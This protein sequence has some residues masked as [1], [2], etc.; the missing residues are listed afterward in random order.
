[1]F[2]PEQQKTLD[3]L[4]SAI[5]EAVPEIVGRNATD[6]MPWTWDDIGLEDVLRALNTERIAPDFRLATH[7]TDPIITM[8]W[9]GT[10]SNKWQLGKPLSE[11][12][13]ECISF[14]SS[15]LHGE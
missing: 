4:T 11:Q 3:E 9:R 2:T 1:M 7:Y 14:L 6:E 15:L 13:P 8:R 5:V 10:N 12:S